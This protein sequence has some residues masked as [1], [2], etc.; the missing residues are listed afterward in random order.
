M[1]DNMGISI[2]YNINLTSKSIDVVLSGYDIYFRP[3]VIL[4]ELKQW[5]YVEVVNN[6]D[7][8]VKTLIG[9]KEKNTLHPAYQV[10]SYVNLLKDYNLYIDKENVNIIPIVYLHNYN[11]N[12]DDDL[13]NKK[14]RPY[15]KNVLM[16]GKN[17][18]EELKYI[19]ENNICFGDNLR[20]INNI[21]K[22]LVKPTKKL[23]DV[24]CSMIED[25]K[26]FVLL[27][28][29]KEIF[30]EINK[31]MKD[32]FVNNKK[33]VLIIK[34]GPGTGKSVLALNALGGLL[35]KGF[36]G[37]YVSKNMAPRDVY[38]SKLFKENKDNFKS[39]FKG[40]GSFIRDKKNKYDFL[41][42]D[43][44]HRL[45]EK[46][47][48]HGNIGENQI[49]EIINAARL[50]VFF[51]DEMQIITLKDIGSVKNIVDMAKV[52]NLDILE[53]ELKSQFRCNGS[54]NYLDF[55]EA[56]LYNKEKKVVF[57]FDFRV[58]DS[59]QDLY[60]LI[61]E[62]NTCNNARIVAGFC[63][64]RDGKNSDNQ[65]YHDISIGDFSLSWNMKHGESFAIRENAINEIGCVY[66]VQGLE[67]DYIG[68][69]IGPDLKYQ[70]GLVVTDYRERA[71]TEKSLYELYQMIKKDRE[72]Y[73]R[74]ADTIIRNTY[75]V[76]LTRG[77]KGCYVYAV[78]D[79]LQKYIKKIAFNKAKNNV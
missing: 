70:D 3:T 37:A 44:A 18:I 5:E 32:A 71:S 8:V 53:Y 69:I 77:I 58:M 60:N 73:E 66:N 50:S 76:L 17:D 56:L 33:R 15:Y 65:E 34:G 12:S 68:V 1:P 9:K 47:G 29:Q 45:Q 78:D 6:Q 14:Y 13:Y 30:E 10:L 64:K 54:N 62:K 43:E 49:K 16:F 75:R 24:V 23:Q 41:L 59:P 11:L 7:A 22:S 67:F 39:I 57:N 48:M 40:S 20:V 74:V 25:K 42:V 27:D 36:L 55:V 38:K 31:W 2:E 26:E 72:Y 19:I 28:E 63:W 52:M 4:L 46:S 61:K 21:D 79:N 35:K 51:V